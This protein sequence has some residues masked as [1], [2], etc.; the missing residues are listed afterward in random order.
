[1]TE[2]VQVWEGKGKPE[3]VR[4]A[5][6][7]FYQFEI[8][9]LRFECEPATESVSDGRRWTTLTVYGPT[10]DSE[11]R[12][13][14]QGVRPRYDLIKVNGTAVQKN[15]VIMGFDRLDEI[16]ENGKSITCITIHL[17]VDVK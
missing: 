4:P 16:D 10:K 12:I 15:A 7:H 17:E 8:D 11:R 1:M 13:T 3:P 14:R 6:A 9:A 2:P 5:P